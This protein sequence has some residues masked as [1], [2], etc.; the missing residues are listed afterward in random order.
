MYLLCVLI[1][2]VALVD[3]AVHA[4][5]EDDAPA[6]ETVPAVHAPLS[7]DP[8]YVL[9][10]GA[11]YTS[12]DVGVRTASSA[13]KE[14]KDASD[15]VAMAKFSPRNRFEAGAHFT[16]GFFKDGS[17]NLS[18]IV[19]GGKYQLGSNRA[20]TVS[21]ALP[22]GDIDDPGLAA[23]FMQTARISSAFRLNTRLQVAAL[24]GYAD[25]GLVVDFLLE[26][27]QV[28]SERLSAYL[29]LIVTSNTSDWEDDLSVRL[30]PNFDIG[31]GDGTVL[32]AGVRVDLR[33]GDEREDVGLFMVLLRDM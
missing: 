23:G 31:L 16:F 1:G 14:F 3:A 13:L 9:P 11:G 19:V 33:G 17:S 6:E 4:Q 24:Q 20:A 7:Y 29:D 8:Y 26:P 21:I 10:G 15:I 22:A 2:V 30:E 12:V 18:S 25:E 28:F 5:N 32:N 27:A